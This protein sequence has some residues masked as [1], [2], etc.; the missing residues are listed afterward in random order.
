MRRTGVVLGSDPIPFL[1]LGYPVLS[2]WMVKGVHSG[3]VVSE[4]EGHAE[5]NT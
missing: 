4:V 2:K 3:E 5:P 1:R